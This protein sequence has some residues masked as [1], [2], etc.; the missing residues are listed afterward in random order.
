MRNDLSQTSL[1]IFGQKSHQA[2][3]D[4]S[5]SAHWRKTVILAAGV[6]HKVLMCSK[7]SMAQEVIHSNQSARHA[8]SD[9]SALYASG[10]GTTLFQ[11]AKKLFLEAQAFCTSQK[12]TPPSI[13]A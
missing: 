4:A 12:N 5:A 13:T 8:P 1:L 6:T 10:I 9:R 11:L 3:V 2:L 7:W